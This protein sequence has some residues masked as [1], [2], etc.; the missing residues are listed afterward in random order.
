[1]I[2]VDSIKDKNV[3]KFIS[4]LIRMCL[5]HDVK[6]ITNPE[7]D[8]VILGGFSDYHRTLEITES[9]D[10]MV[11]SV[12]VHEYCHMLQW[13]ENDPVYIAKYRNLDPTTVVDNWLNGRHYSAK[14]L[15]AC[16]SL[17]KRLEYDCDVRAVEQIKIWNL[18][19]DCDFYTQCAI[20]YSYYHDYLRHTRKQGKNVPYESDEV[21][22]RI[23]PDFST[24][25]LAIR[26]LIIE[27]LIDKN[28]TNVL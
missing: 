25:D 22:Q 20:G 21:L 26:D 27:E 23:M 12:L 19:I 9:S 15:D 5:K 7:K 11:L 10:D 6:F 3:K 2:Y 16:F 24:R 18:P 28:N 4:H 1:M 14:T 13:L 8:S 17:L